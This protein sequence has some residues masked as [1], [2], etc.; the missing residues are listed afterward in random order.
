[1]TVTVIGTNDPPVIKYLNGDVATFTEGDGAATAHRVLL[2]QAGTLGTAALV[3]DEDNDEFGGGRLSVEILGA[4]FTEDV[5]GFSA[6]G[7][8]TY[9]T[10]EDPIT[11]NIGGTV[12]YNGS[13]IG[14]YL[15]TQNA[16]KMTVDLTSDATKEG[17]SKLVQSITYYNLDTVNPTT[18]DRTV[19]FM[20]WDGD[21]TGPGMLGL[22]S[23]IADV[24][25]HVVAT[26]DAPVIS[27]LNGDSVSYF[28]ESAPA[29]L[30]RIGVSGTST[31]LAVSVSD[32]D[33]PNFDG[34]RLKVQ[35]TG[36]TSEPT[37]GLSTLD[38]IGFRDGGYAGISYDGYNVKFNDTPIGTATYV[39]GIFTMD[40]ELNENANATNVS[41]LIQNITYYSKDT[42]DFRDGYRTVRFSLSDGDGGGVADATADAT[43]RVSGVNDAP[44]IL[45]IDSDVAV[46]YETMGSV[47]LDTGSNA[48]VVDVDTADFSGGFI[49]AQITS[50]FG[51]STSED[52]LG[53]KAVTGV[54]IGGEWDPVNHRLLIPLGTGTA[55]TND[56]VDAIVRN[57]YYSNDFAAADQS[58]TESDRNV[59][60]FM[61]DGDDSNFAIGDMPSSPVYNMTVKVVGQN[62][63]PVLGTLTES[64]K[65]VENDSA[66]ELLLAGPIP[67]H[68]YVTDVDSPNFDGGRLV[69]QITEG[70]K[71]AE[72]V[73]SVA[74]YLQSE[75]SITASSLDGDT[76]AGKVTFVD[77]QHVFYGSSRIGTASYDKNYGKLTID[78]TEYA[79]TS[80]V[81]MLMQN[82]TYANTDSNDPTVGDRKISYQ[83]FDGDGS[84]YG[85]SDA[86]K[87]VEVTVNVSGVNDA[88]E[89][90]NLNGDV[91]TYKEGAVSE[92]FVDKDINAWVRDVDNDNDAGQKYS[93]LTVQITK[94]VVSGNNNEDVLSIVSEG[95]HW[96]QIRVDTA[97]IVYYGGNKIGSIT[98]APGD[99]SFG[100]TFNQN[101]NSEAIA[102]LIQSITYRNAGAGGTNT[103]N[104]TPGDRTILYSLTDYGVGGVG[105]ATGTAQSIVTVEAVNS[106]PVIY[107]IAETVAFIEGDN[108]TGVFIDGNNVA[109]ATNAYVSDPDSADFNTGHLTVK[110]VNPISSEDKLGFSGRNGIFVNGAGSNELSYNGS[111]IGTFTYTAGTATLDVTLNANAKTNAVSALI[112]SVYYVNTN[113]ANPVT[114]DRNVDFRLSDG[115][116]ATSL[117]NIATVHVVAVNDAPVIN[118]IQG[119][120][121]TFYERGNAVVFDVG[122][123][124]FVS[125]PDST[126]FSGGNFTAEI[127]AGAD[128]T[129]DVL[130]VRNQGTGAGQ[131]G[132]VTTADNVGAVFYGG[133]QIGVATFV[134][135]DADIA[136]GKLTVTLNANA[137]TTAVSALAQN[138][139]YSNKDTV[140]PTKGNRQVRFTMNDGDGTANGGQNTAAYVYA[141]VGVVGVNSPPEIY[142][143]NRDFIDN[144]TEG[145]PAVVLD[146][147]GTAYFEKAYVQDADSTEFGGGR[148]Y[149]QVV[150]GY[151]KTEDVLSV[152]NVGDISYSTSTGVVQYGT[153]TIGNV[154]WNSA[155]GMLDIELTGNDANATS[156]GALVQAITYQNTDS[157]TPTPGDR[158]VRFLLWDGGN[159]PDPVLGAS[160][161]YHNV[162]VTV[163]EVNSPPI[164]WN[165]N[166]DSVGWSEGADPVLIDKSVNGYVSDV[167]SPN[168]DGGRL[169]IRFAQNYVNGEDTLTVRDQSVTGGSLGFDGLSVVSYNSKPFG[170]VLFN[171]GTGTFAVDLNENADS[172]A[173]SALIQNVMYKNNGGASPTQGNRQ[174]QYV[175]YDGDGGLGSSAYVYS[176][177]TVTSV[178]T[179]PIIHNLAGDTIEYL[180]NTA[181]TQMIMD[182]GLKASVTDVDLEPVTFFNGGRLDVQIV[183]GFNAAKD[184]EDVLGIKNVGDTYGQIGLDTTNKL[185]RFEGV[186]IG[187]YT[188]NQANHTLTVDFTSDK[189]TE[190]A[191]SALIQNV[192]YTNADA[193]SP[194]QGWRDVEFKVY[195]GDGAN[196]TSL[197]YHVSVNVVDVNDAPV[198]TKLADETGKLGTTK[199]IPIDFT[200]GVF[201]SADA[202]LL[203]TGENAV[204]TDVDLKNNFKDGKLTV[205]I[206]SGGDAL[207][208]V[209]GVRNEGNSLHQI[210]VNVAGNISYG[211]EQI[212]QAAFAQTSGLLTVTLNDKATPE[213]VSSLIQNVQYNNSD[214]DN[215]TEGIRQIQFAV[216]DDRGASSPAHDIFV[217]VHAVN[218]PPV[219]SNIQ[220]D[221]VAFM[222]RTAAVVIDKGLDGKITDVDTTSFGGGILTVDNEVVFDKDAAGNP[223]EWLSINNEGSAA[224][225][226]GFNGFDPFTRYGSVSYGGVAVAMAHQDALA[227]DVDVTFNDKA[228]ASIVAAVMRNITYQNLDTVN[229]TAG[230]RT[231]RFSM[232]DGDG[233]VWNG[234][235]HSVSENV[236]AT[237]LVVERNDAPVIHDLANDSISYYKNEGLKLLD[238]GD[239][240][241]KASVTDPDSKDFNGGYL[242]VQITNPLS[243]YEKL[244]ISTAAGTKINVVNNA[245]FYDS[246]QIGTVTMMGDVMM[247]VNLIASA[248]ETSVGALIQSIGYQNT[249]TVNP[250][251]GTRN[252]RF[253]MY[254]GDGPDG[255]SLA[256]DT[257]VNVSGNRPPVVD[258]GVMPEA[259]NVWQVNE[260][261]VNTLN[262][263]DVNAFKDPD[264]DVMTYKAQ[265]IDADGNLYHYLDGSK[266]DG[267]LPGWIA[268]NEQKGT[269]IATPMVAGLEDVRV[270]VFASD[271]V[272]GAGQAETTFTVSVLKGEVNHK[273]YF[274]RLDQYGDPVLDDHDNNS[275]TASLPILDPN[276]SF[277]ISEHIVAPSATMSDVDNRLVMVKAMDADGDTVTYRITGGNGAGNFGIDAATG[278]ISLIHTGTGTP[279]N[280]ADDIN[281]ETGPKAFTLNVE[282]KDSKGAF[283]E[284]TVTIF[285]SDE[286][287]VPTANAIPV[288]YVKAG[289]DFIMNFDD[290]AIGGVK[291]FNDEDGD[292]L[293][294]SAQATPSWLSF[295][296]PS[297][298]QGTVPAGTPIGTVYEIKLYADD[299]NT[300]TTN[301][302]IENTFQI[303]VVASATGLRDA[304]RYLDA[305]QTGGYEDYLPADG[306][307]VAIHEVA[308]YAQAAQSAEPDMAADADMLEALNLLDKG[309]WNDMPA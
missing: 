144:Y 83:L 205:K 203:D 229:I 253:T 209:L 278:K 79:N 233:T 58:F 183:S 128:S 238:T 27:F 196:G 136:A 101:A 285:I 162:T 76:A 107:N 189:A 23:N 100:I 273:P 155:V 168:F 53:L 78:L 129:D 306:Y 74:D 117:A 75:A 119:D 19:R 116:G 171:A 123:A 181:G 45:N 124:A 84:A 295:I 149:V 176:T 263:N 236:F 180:E 161:S 175:M 277:N 70:Y 126:D 159:G 11:H 13:N 127:T 22:S 145:Q 2:D 93:S 18:S 44:M 280:F 66:A 64:W 16:G 173:V 55:V 77:G 294:Y 265:R 141:T 164:I 14:S 151:D 217:N 218:D 99:T 88:P 237:V 120:S 210:G 131:I 264:G 143:L 249:N 115:D 255:S 185:V 114:T 172:N 56:Q 57:I 224:G 106:A 48:D 30:D 97:S 138:I 190:R 34:G 192:T 49:V 299:D 150:G 199:L 82:I 87:T 292:V 282:A 35:I 112:Q 186:T 227:G 46:F 303:K 122:A 247:K 139:T 81:S 242:S 193:D 279:T 269:F 40:V 85:G 191:V 220:G 271:G 286:N 110:I 275:A 178:N 60:I 61:N 50:G 188:P 252:I 234:L 239:V 204:V 108:N 43:V 283:S 156:V 146:Q 160:S 232:N 208:D 198:I 187:K 307:G 293:F 59:R 302:L 90:F 104:P 219:I 65:Y 284:G 5:L 254:D 244:G 262:L 301:P 167:D 194:Y 308:M 257:L 10:A 134:P 297:F 86:S 133:T 24:K 37:G 289:S 54:T 200:E 276:V 201:G 259:A 67:S 125:D 89:I 147:K 80:T 281:F 267:A 211:S 158:T 197:G 21:G 163:K 170:T 6:G 148:L 300:V 202:K 298:L 250:S 153:D 38:M 103:S 287:D 296:S 184:A 71:K 33:S 288:Q 142:N 41:A 206:V 20:M 17:M 215:P 241:Q 165:I 73:L 1:M 272:A 291:A 132:Y 182:Q 304:V 195:D 179:P 63:P 12:V 261:F 68:F 29:V 36:S 245:V 137:T 8:L 235:G 42:A 98:D 25:L 157:V 28:E 96:D 270:E 231:I 258:K 26:N 135:N 207:E 39:P 105:F 225:K 246:S 95:D 223:Q 248:N 130:S 251:A 121:V 32:L 113:T 152:A 260:A 72:D 94:T 174:L 214:T 118:N 222:E 109:N 230:E 212:G 240:N 309:V 243:S 140:M 226:V 177:V 102:A 92:V 7:L 256:Y 169:E 166:G 91:V 216:W 290:A 266:P 9:S 305:D 154:R 15:W 47:T 31:Y 213:A 3:T 4:D 274:V 52:V 51:S 268:L 62:D 111:G 228:D 221:T 69:V